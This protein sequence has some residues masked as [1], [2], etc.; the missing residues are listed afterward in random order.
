MMLKFF[1]I[2]FFFMGAL[3]FGQQY[4]FT[5]VID[6]EATE[7]KSQDNTGTCW[8]FSATSFL[9]SEII[10]MNG[11]R[12]DIS[13]MYNVYNTYNKKSWNYI[14]RQGKTQFGEGGLAHD[15]INSVRENGLV[16]ETAYSGLLS[17]KTTHN[18]SEMANALSGVLK[19]YIKNAKKS[20][21]WKAAV[22]A[23]LQRYLGRKPA[24]FNYEGAQYT[25]QSFLKMTGLN[26]DDYVSNTSFSHR[27]FYTSF[28]RNIPDNFSN[29]T[30]YN[31]PLDEFT[32]IIDHALKNGYTLSWDA[33]VSERTFSSKHGVAFIP[34]S[35]S[36]K[37]RGLNKPVK[38]KAISQEYRQ[39]QFENYAT[40]DDH[41]MHIIGVVKDQN[42]ATY[43]KV[44]N[45]W[46]TNPE[47]IGNDGYV[48]VSDAYMRLKSISVLLHKDALPEELRKR[49]GL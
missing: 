38:E 7:V 23:I 33:D 30:F 48:Y 44:K 19:S 2:A 42:G 8:S 41:L 14:M 29:G 5:P 36:E 11:K 27:P 13:E 4:Q 31:V 34:E 12:I 16:P 6:I 3:V 20:D 49:L 40:T 39:Q 22:N 45:S 17:G 28:I 37:S 47:R 10:R 35:D 18:H 32:T 15:V 26:M 46:G 1:R 9:E 21:G 25:P 24:G 43:Y